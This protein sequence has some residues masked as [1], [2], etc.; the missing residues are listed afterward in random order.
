MAKVSRLYGWLGWVVLGTGLCAVV[1]TS[2]F[3]G[4]VEEAVAYEQTLGTDAGLSADQLR[5][6]I[7]GVQGQISQLRSLQIVN[8]VQALSLLTRLSSRYQLLPQVQFHQQ[9]NMLTCHMTTKGD[10]RAIWSFLT[11]L[12][13][14]HERSQGSV[15]L[16]AYEMTT[17]GE[18]AIALSLDLN[19][20]TRPAGDKL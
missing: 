11:S 5:S 16:R 18:N 3:R 8:Q 10:E 6:R 17:S 1:T 12:D 2:I 14:L 13:L 9:G 7:G 19:L 20:L 4:Q 15:I